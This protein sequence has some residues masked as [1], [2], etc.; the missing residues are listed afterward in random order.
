MSGA[1]IFVQPTVRQ[2]ECL[3][4]CGACCKFVRL[5]VPPTYQETDTRGWLQLHGIRLTTIDG[6]TFATIDRRCDALTDDNRCSLYGKPERPQL[7]ADWPATPGAM[8]G[9]E[10]VCGYRFEEVHAPV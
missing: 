9:L 3:P 1:G 8:A 10:D 5:Q 7:C 6:A 4:N 2:G